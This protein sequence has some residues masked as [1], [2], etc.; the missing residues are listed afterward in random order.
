LSSAPE[1]QLG[2]VGFAGGKHLVLVNHGVV[3]GPDG[4]SQ[5]ESAAGVFVLPL[6][7]PEIETANGNF[8]VLTNHFGFTISG[9]SGQVV[10]VEASSDLAE[11]GW[12]PIQTNTVQG[13]S[14]YFR[15]QQWTNHPVRF[16]RVQM[17]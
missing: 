9:P 3:L 13:D 14:L 8:G 16:Y 7:A 15:D 5:V 12:Q 1:N 10:V 4:I 11:S 6:A 17:P 2:G